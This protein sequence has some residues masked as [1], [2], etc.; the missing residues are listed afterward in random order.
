MAKTNPEGLEMVVD[1]FE[2]DLYSSRTSGELAC[3]RLKTDDPSYTCRVSFWPAGADLPA[4]TVNHDELHVE[5]HYPYAAMGH[6][7]DML[8]DPDQMVC[9]IF[10]GPDTSRLVGKVP[11]LQ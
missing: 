1:S 2:E 6:V 11:T 10:D 8:R 7:L 9:V 3:I 5:L 4:A